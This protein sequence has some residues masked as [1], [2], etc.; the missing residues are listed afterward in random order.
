M[1]SFVSKTLEKFMNVRVIKN[2]K[3]SGKLLNLDFLSVDNQMDD[4]SLFVAFVTKQTLQ[5]LLDDGDIADYAV[6]R[7][8][9]GVRILYTTAILSHIRST[10]SL[11]DDLLH[12]A[13]FLNF[14][15]EKRQHLMQWKVLPIAFCICIL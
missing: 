2:A 15:R 14:E 12:S 4:S 10:F 3:E 8:Y 11:K 9:K 5:K 7:F 1:E 13:R 6:K